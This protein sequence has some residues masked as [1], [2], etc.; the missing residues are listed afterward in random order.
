MEAWNDPHHPNLAKG[1]AAIFTFLTSI[2]LIVV[3]MSQDW[4]TGPVAKAGTGDIALFVS[5]VYS[6][7]AFSIARTLELR[8]WRKALR[9]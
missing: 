1:Y 9:H 5:F 3:S 8:M 7:L 2:G 4:W 6:V